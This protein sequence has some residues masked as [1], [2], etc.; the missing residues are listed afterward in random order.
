MTLRLHPL[1][2]LAASTALAGCNLAPTYVRP[3]GAVPAAL[4]QGGIYPVAATD[5]RDITAIG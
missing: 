1:W 5:A 3:V 2:A 4:P